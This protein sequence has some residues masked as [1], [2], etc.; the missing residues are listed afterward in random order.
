MTEERPLDFSSRVTG[1]PSSAFHAPHSSSTA[2]PAPNSAQK[3]SSFTPNIASRGSLLGS[4]GGASKPRRLSEQNLRQF[5]L[6]QQTNPKNSLEKREQEL[7]ERRVNEYLLSLDKHSRSQLSKSQ[8]I[9]SY[10]KTVEYKKQC[11]KHQFSKTFPK[12][13]FT[14]DVDPGIF[15]DPAFKHLLPNS[16][17]RKYST[18][19]IAEKDRHKLTGEAF[20]SK[21]L[22]GI[23]E[24]TSAFLKATGRP[25]LAMQEWLTKR[26]TLLLE[27]DRLRKWVSG[28]L[29]DNPDTA[30][31]TNVEEVVKIWQQKRR[32]Y[33]VEQWISIYYLEDLAKMSVNDL[34]RDYR[35]EVP[36]GPY[37]ADVEEAA[38]TT[39]VS[40]AASPLAARS[41]LSTLHSTQKPLTS[42]PASP[43]SQRQ[44]V[45]R[46]TGA[47]A[48]AFVYQPRYKPNQ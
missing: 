41:N 20:E 14:E 37:N 47:A 45:S 2:G 22:P 30:N 23:D 18:I 43:N 36:Q 7:I 46:G 31:K 39:A 1:G 19:N 26:S 6:E 27:R 11:E 13:Y 44:Q 33:T 8:L 5:D 25:D 32:E 34:L 35:T 17:S 28:W 40:Q 48:G 10:E 42:S 4:S 29:S 12:E 3:H 21:L 38:F 15:L 24:A 9:K 16:A